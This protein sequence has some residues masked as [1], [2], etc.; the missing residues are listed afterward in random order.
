MPAYAM[1]GRDPPPS[2]PLIAVTPSDRE[3]KLL[4]AAVALSTESRRFVRRGILASRKRL[5]KPPVTEHE[6]H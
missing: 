4:P 6:P 5:R 2:R 1:S 3:W